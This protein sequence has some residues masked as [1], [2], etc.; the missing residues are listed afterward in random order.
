[1]KRLPLIVSLAVFPLVAIAAE[2]NSS[3]AGLDGAPWVW[4]SPDSPGQAGAKTPERA[5]VLISGTSLSG[6]LFLANREYARFKGVIKAASHNVDVNG[7]TTLV[8]EISATQLT[9]GGTGAGQKLA[10]KGAY[11]KHQAAEIDAIGQAG[12]YE[13]LTLSKSGEDGAPVIISRLQLP[14]Q[15]R[16]AAR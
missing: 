10:L 14:A 6:R 12:S 16:V 9:G 11:T 4:C 7:A 3:N 15:L 8:W 13:V 5:E 2:P 1:M